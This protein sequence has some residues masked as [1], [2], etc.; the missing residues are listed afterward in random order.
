MDC[1]FREFIGAKKLKYYYKQ[2]GVQ[3]ILTYYKQYLILNHKWM[4]GFYQKINVQLKKHCDVRE[5]NF[6]M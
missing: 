1:Y 3:L 2:S 6:M 4:N 5:I